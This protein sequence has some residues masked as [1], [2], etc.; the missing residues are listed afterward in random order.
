MFWRDEQAYINIS[1]WNLHIC[2]C[3]PPDTMSTT[4]VTGH[5]APQQLEPVYT[6]HMKENAANPF[7]LL[8][9][10]R[11]TDYNWVLLAFFALCSY[12]G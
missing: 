11:I 4:G 2:H 1:E 9:G 8:S 3:V 10:D 7:V 6:W 5:I 12:A